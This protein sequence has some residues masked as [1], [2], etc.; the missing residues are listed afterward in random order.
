[1]RPIHLYILPMQPPSLLTL[2]LTHSNGERQNKYIKYELQKLQNKFALSPIQMFISFFLFPFFWGGGNRM[3]AWRLFPRTHSPFSQK[4]LQWPR[5][6][7]RGYCGWPTILEDFL[8]L[9][10]EYWVYRYIAP[11]LSVQPIF[12]YLWVLISLILLHPF[13]SFQL[14]NTRQE[15]KKRIERKY[16]LQITSC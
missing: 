15:K 14:P 6:H 16:C 7:Q 13:P 4:S 2:R 11:C 9:S 12:V 10:F 5:A 8:H 1:M 3:Q